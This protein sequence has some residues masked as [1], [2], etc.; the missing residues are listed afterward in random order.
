MQGSSEGVYEVDID[1]TRGAILDKLIQKKTFFQR[2][3]DGGFVGYVI[4]LLG[5]GGVALASER[6]YV[7][8]NTLDSIREQ[9]N[10]D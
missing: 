3:A 7:L 8:R 4:I 6:I 2:I 5:L 10:S 1:P 9:E